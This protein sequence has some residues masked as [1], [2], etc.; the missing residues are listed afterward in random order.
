MG[1]TPQGVV[2]YF[3]RHVSSLGNL[4][5][6]QYKPNLYLFGIWES[7]PE[8]F[9]LQPLAEPYV[10]LSVHTAPISTPFPNTSAQTFWVPSF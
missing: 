10:N 1:N 3:A 9:H 5:G 8:E 4:F 6:G 7:R 2:F